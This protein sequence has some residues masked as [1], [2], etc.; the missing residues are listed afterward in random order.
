MVVSTT[1][2]TPGRTRGGSGCYAL[3]RDGGEVDRAGALPAQ[4]AASALLQLVHVHVRGRGGEARGGDTLEALV[5]GHF[6]GAEVCRAVQHPLRNIADVGDH[7]K[8][9]GRGQ[10][11]AVVAPSELLPLPVVLGIQHR[12]HVLGPG[13]DRAATA[14]RGELEVEALPQHGVD[15]VDA[16]FP[17]R[18][19]LHRLV[20]QLGRP[21]DDPLHT[22]RLVVPEEDRERVGSHVDALQALADLGE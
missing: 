3:A 8:V 10:G 15:F 22:V 21:R 4:E 17:Q 6:G 11:V 19:L 20:E 14:P 7:E 5:A 1:N 2:R 13:D 16:A 9:G 18:H 12:G